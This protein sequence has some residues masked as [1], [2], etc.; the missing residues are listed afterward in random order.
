[1]DVLGV[2]PDPHTLLGHRQRM[3]NFFNR[4]LSYLGERGHGLHS[5]RA[6]EGFDPLVPASAADFD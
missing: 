1:M 5:M 4:W 2:F 6:I 3:N